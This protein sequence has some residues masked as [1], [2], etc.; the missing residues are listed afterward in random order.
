MP[1]VSVPPYPPLFK[2]P[3]G[4]WICTKYAVCSQKKGEI[5]KQERKGERW[6]GAMN[7]E[8]RKDEK[9]INVRIREY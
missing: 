5:E 9:R 1:S 6:S 4:N 7:G 2:L 8:E 3:P